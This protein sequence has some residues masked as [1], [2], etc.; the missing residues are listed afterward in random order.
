MGVPGAQIPVPP[1]GV[2]HSKLLRS[3]QSAL[4]GR[5]PWGPPVQ[6]GLVPTSLRVGSTPCGRSSRAWCISLSRG[7]LPLAVEPLQ[8]LVR[9]MLGFLPSTLRLSSSSFS[10]LSWEPL[11]ASSVER[12]AWLSLSRGV[13]WKLW[14]SCPER[15]LRVRERE[16]R[17]PPKITLNPQE[18]W[19][20]LNPSLLRLCPLPSEH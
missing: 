2:I 17:H 14:T 20:L 11:R 3:P 10:G 6:L 18:S 15:S 5:I 16:D 9:F 1:G 4:W 12:P 7:R 8:L 19:H 13:S